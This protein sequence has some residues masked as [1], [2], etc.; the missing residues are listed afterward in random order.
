MKF[1]IKATIQIGP[2]TFTV[3][4]APKSAPLSD[5]EYAFGRTHRTAQ[6]EPAAG[7]FVCAVG[8]GQIRIGNSGKPWIQL[9][10]GVSAAPGRVQVYVRSIP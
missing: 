7:S 6:T 1:Q 3:D 10:R 8:P 9:D 5:F 4:T 2:Y